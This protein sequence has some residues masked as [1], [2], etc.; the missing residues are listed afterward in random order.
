MSGVSLQIDLQGEEAIATAL[1]NLAHRA[2]HLEPAL[3]DMG[4]HFMRSIDERFDAQKS[5]DG[6]PWEPNK[7]ATLAKKRRPEILTESKRLRDSIVYNVEDGGLEIGTNVIYG[8]IHQLGG[9]AGRGVTLPER[10][11]LG[12]SDDDRDAILEIAS[13]YLAEAV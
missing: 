11:Y 5:P 4:E 8:A 12:V 9:Q 3:K 2:S 10:P 6:Q 7:P 1:A 13:D